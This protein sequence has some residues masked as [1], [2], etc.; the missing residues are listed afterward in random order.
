MN[1]VAVERLRLLFLGANW[2]RILDFTRQYERL[3]LILLAIAAV[4]AGNESSKTEEGLQKLDAGLRQLLYKCTG[5]SGCRNAASEYL[6]RLC[7]PDYR[8]NYG[9]DTAAFLRENAKARFP[10]VLHASAT[11][12]DSPELE[13]FGVHSIALPNERKPTF[14][15]SEAKDLG[16][17]RVSSLRLAN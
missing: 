7:K 11:R 2:Q 13:E 1:A 12:F 14:T 9:E 8:G 16:D 17:P 6:P 3:T 15:G 5:D 10:F 4:L